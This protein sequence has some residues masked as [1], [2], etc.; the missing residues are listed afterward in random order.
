MLGDEF[1]MTSYAEYF[2]NAFVEKDSDFNNMGYLKSHF[3]VYG[4]GQRNPAATLRNSN[5]IS[6]VRN[7]LVE[8]INKFVIFPKV[9]LIVLEDDLIHA[10]NHYTDGI[11][12]LLGSITEWLANELHHLVITQK[13]K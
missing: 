12:Q 13:E 4:F 6:R 3:D 7:A 1:M 2:Q 9:I 11:S 8:A 5:M 10:A